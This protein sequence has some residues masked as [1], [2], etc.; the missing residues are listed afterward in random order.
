MGPNAEVVL[1]VL[2]GVLGVM[3]MFFIIVLAYKL[4]AEFINMVNRA[5]TDFF[6]FR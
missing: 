6:R 3:T 4:V 1:Y 5:F 2:A